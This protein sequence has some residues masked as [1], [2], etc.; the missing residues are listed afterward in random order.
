[1]SAI[2]LYHQNMS[3]P[4]LNVLEITKSE[5]K[6]SNR[7]RLSNS[8]DP[9][10]PTMATKTKNE[11]NVCCPRSA[12]VSLLESSQLLLLPMKSHLESKERK[13]HRRSNYVLVG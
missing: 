2:C 10:M 4:L 1:M 8:F 6:T 3:G 5:L 7:D 11:Y 13:R 9:A 12:E